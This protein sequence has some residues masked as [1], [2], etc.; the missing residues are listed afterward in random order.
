MEKNRKRLA[1]LFTVCF[2]VIAIIAARQ[3]VPTL[4]FFQPAPLLSFKDSDINRIDLVGMNKKQTLVRQNGTWI[5]PVN[6]TDFPADSDKVNNLLKTLHIMSADSVVSRNKNK[7]GNFGIGTSKIV[8]ETKSKTSTLY[9]GTASLGDNAYARLDNQDM[10]FDAKNLGTVYLDTDYRNLY[11]PIIGNTGNVQS[12]QIDYQGE[13]VTLTQ[14]GN[15]WHN[16]SDTPVSDSIVDTYLQNVA[17]LQGSDILPRHTPP[18]GSLLLTVTVKEKGKDKTI[19]FYSASKQQIEVDVAGA[20]YLYVLPEVY[21][22]ALEKKGS[23]FTSPT[24]QP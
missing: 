4:P 3:Y 20:P 2:F 8:L 19:R 16:Q 11:I 23:D 15:T 7:F 9:V 18:A 6:G 10:V 12:V 1:A 22:S 5:V 14:S 17:H 24:V 13:T 21:V